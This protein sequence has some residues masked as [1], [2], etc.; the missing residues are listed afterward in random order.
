MTIK[1]ELMPEY[2][3]YY[4]PEYPGRPLEYVRDEEGAGWLC[5]EGVDRNLDLR[6]Q[7]CWRCDEVAFPFGGR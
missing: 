4:E 3:E 1:K 7:D 2:P 6:E 5:D